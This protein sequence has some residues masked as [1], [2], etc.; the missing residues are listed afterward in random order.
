V[1]QEEDDG[2]R[3]IKM[4]AQTVDSVSRLVYS[5]FTMTNTNTKTNTHQTLEELA[6]QMAL[7]IE[8]GRAQ[9]MRMFAAVRKMKAKLAARR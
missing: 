5:G 1:A 6:A 3:K 4:I 7:E 2:E 8:A 9:R